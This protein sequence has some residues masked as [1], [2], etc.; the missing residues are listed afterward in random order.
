MFRVFLLQDRFAEIWI[1]DS[2]NAL[3]SYTL[4]TDLFADIHFCDFVLYGESREGL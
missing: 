3:V 1:R 2:Q 4:K